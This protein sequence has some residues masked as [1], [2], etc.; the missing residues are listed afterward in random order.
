MS[1]QREFDVVICGGGLAGL[2]LARHLKLDQPELSVAVI[3]RLTRPLPEAAFKVG[4]S[5]IELGTYYFGQVLKLDRYFRTK[6]LP[7]FGL[8]F[9]LGKSHEPLTQR[10]E[11]GQTM[12]PPVPSYQID[13]GR[14]ETDLREFVAE[15]GVILF[16]GCS[17]D[18]IELAEGDT[19]HIIRCRRKDDSE[20]FTLT[21]QWVVDALGRRRLL[22]TKLGLK[23]EHEHRA[24]A[25]WWRYT[26]RIDVDVMG[27]QDGSKFPHQ[28][29]EDRYFSTNHMM[30]R[31]YWV[32][33]IP[34]GSGNTSVGIVTDD[35]IHPQN[36][37]GKSYE[38][39]LEWLQKN[40]PKV[41]DFVRD[42]P[43]MD[44]LSLKRY[45]YA[46][47]QVFSHT[48][49]SCVGE[50]GFFLDPLYSY[51]SDFIAVT[52]T[53]T[54]EMI[55]RER[56]GSLTEKMVADYN[57]L[58]LDNLYKICLGFYE[59][60]YK[61]FGHPQIFTP[62]LTWDTAIYWSWMYQLYVQGMLL[63][64]TEDVFTLGERFRQ[65]N[66]RVEKLLADWSEKAPPRPLYVLGDMTRMRLMMLLG[67]DLASRRGPEQMMKIAR[68]NLDRLEEFALV[69]FWQA[70][71]ECYPNHP[72]LKKKPWV[73]AW[74]MHLEPD[75][76]E[77]D[78][79]FEPETASRPLQSMRDNFSG[80]F[81]PQSLRERILYNLPYQLLH[82]GKGFVYY[83]IVTWIR[84]I[85]FVN[86]PAM[87]VR[88]ALIKDY[89][90]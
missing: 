18:D 87:W 43:P 68:K 3:D 31:G 19:A 17:V 14:L 5:S 37:Y 70:V 28:L 55:R 9:F 42:L 21:G 48:R 75:Q 1:D 65:L 64:P 54:V 73:N 66:T 12:F 39:A 79:V 84:R 74:R 33:F 57:R 22:Q 50:A 82:L 10:P 78:G 69:L 63:N 13:R 20:S 49:W 72:M 53:L 16:E 24:S 7:K 26:G 62:K 23:R 88:W 15:M 81:G 85:I 46:S 59:G 45:S 38:Q 76:W 56:A 6:H 41:W 90:S 77:A 34:L 80:I 47:A 4:E 61:I 29:I 71:S 67:L 52:N 35:D 83:K 32:W 36:T 30:D 58:V 11:A 60:M 8:R 89:P 2:T 27:T 25:A 40:E 51:G 86:K 44:F